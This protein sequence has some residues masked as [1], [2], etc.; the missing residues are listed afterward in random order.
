MIQINKA[1]LSLGDNPP[2][3]YPEYD[4]D[5]DDSS[6]NGDES[7]VSYQIDS[8]TESFDTYRDKGLRL[9]KE[10]WPRHRTDDFVITDMK[11]GSGKRFFG[12]TV[13][14]SD[15]PTDD[16]NAE[17]LPPDTD[18]DSDILPCGDY[19]LRVPRWNRYQNY[20]RLQLCLAERY[21]LPVG[22]RV[23]IMV[24]LDNTSDNALG[25]PYSL[26]PKIPGQR[27]ELLWTNLNK[28]QKLHIAHD[29][30]NLYSSIYASPNPFGGYPQFGDEEQP[31]QVIRTCP[32]ALVEN[33]QERVLF[34]DDP[35][36]MILGTVSKW[37]D[38]SAAYH[39]LRWP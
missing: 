4:T 14:K 12:I 13:Q 32:L 22:I 2:R 26:Q 35:L 1:N 31:E 24:Y 5:T 23:P 9:C 28:E 36:H 10:L 30:A 19:V 20:N 39:E 21:T 25:Q 18:G 7:H 27:L 29:L 15:V 17:S 33:D 8:E 3:A 16:S 37:L 6:E 11:E 38:R 34:T